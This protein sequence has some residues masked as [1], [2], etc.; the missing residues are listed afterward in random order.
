MVG[1]V[2]ACRDWGL[3]LSH[4][5]GVGGWLVERDLPDWIYG[6][7][8]HGGSTCWRGGGWGVGISGLAAGAAGAQRV[9]CAV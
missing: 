6:I 4:G 9:G 2:V 7:G 8:W 5:S 3:T 1:R